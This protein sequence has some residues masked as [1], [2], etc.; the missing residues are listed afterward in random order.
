MTVPLDPE[1]QVTS[2]TNESWGA[3]SE[4]IE[5]QSWAN[6]DWV[7][8]PPSDQY[9][10]MSDWDPP[11]QESGFVTQGRSGYRGSGDG[12]S[13]GRG[14]G[15]RGRGGRGRDGNISKLMLLFSFST[16]IKSN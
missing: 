8:D 16:I 11:R 15:G 5:T 6:E 1:P 14:R 4:P 12:R 2:W 13:R 9:Q 3:Q 7:G 10:G